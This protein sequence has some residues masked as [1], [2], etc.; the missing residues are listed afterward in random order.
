MKKCLGCGIVL[1]NKEQNTLGY[2]ENLE[3]KFC[4]RCYKLKNYGQYQ[5]VP[6]TNKD[7]RQILNK[8]KKDEP[9]LYIT[10]VLTLDCLGIEQFKNTILVI[11][12]KDILPKS[13]KKDKIINY[14]KNQYPSIK[15]I[16]FISS[17]TGEGIKELHNKLLEYKKIYLVG[18]TNSGKSTLINKLLHF[19]SDN[20]S[21]IITTSMY[22][23]TTLN[24]IEIKL[25]NL[26]II[27]TPG[28]INKESI[29]NYIKESDIKK[30]TPKKEIKPKSCQIEG[31]GSI[32]IENMIRIDY[33]TKNKNSIVIYTANNLNIKFISKKNNVLHNYPKQEFILKDKQDIVIPGLGFIKCTKK[34]NLTIYKVSGTVLKV[35]DNL[36]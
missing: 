31:T 30:I 22:P 7:Y 16:Y 1:Q 18:T 9:V 6:L 28:L 32:L 26:T 36:I 5:S 20:H 27:D 24:T 12:K 17:K 2:T 25:D 19:Y 8:I 14:M 35:R 11:T 33:Q 23:S 21:N 15:D 10:D 3:N 29:I 13:T 34:I 4:Q